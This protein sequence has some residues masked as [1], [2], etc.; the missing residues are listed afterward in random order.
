MLIILKGEA[1]VIFTDVDGLSHEIIT[2]RTGDVIGLSNLLQ[3]S[4]SFLL[5][6]TLFVQGFE[7]FGDIVS[8]QD[9]LECLKVDDPQQVLELYERKQ[10][11]ELLQ[12]PNRDSMRV[13]RQMMT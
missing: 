5:I 4:V 12:D 13:V 9:D 8:Q 10:L 7:T 6:F 1:V 2:L 3:I 11:A